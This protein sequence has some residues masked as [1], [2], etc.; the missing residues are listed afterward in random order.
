[1]AGFR[2]AA[3]AKNFEKGVYMMESKVYVP[4]SDDIHLVSSKNGSIMY[5]FFNV[6]SDN[7][8]VLDIGIYKQGSKWYAFIQGDNGKIWD[9]ERIS[10]LDGD[11]FYMEVNF[12]SDEII[13]RVDGDEVLNYDPSNHWMTRELVSS[14]DIAHAGFEITLV[15]ADN[16]W[17]NFNSKASHEGDSL[18]A[19]FKNAKMKEC[20]IYNQ[21]GE[22]VSIKS[23]F[24][25][26]DGSKFDDEADEC[27]SV[28]EYTNGFRTS[29][30]LNKTKTRF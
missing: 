13:L 11:R 19:F 12:R 29:I 20:T 5:M 23:P 21:E 26:G 10:N 18:R 27:V 14:T 24:I 25:D 30:D 3:Q 22:R 16:D 2:A 6:N 8:A 9:A 4:D 15:P 28:Y 17:D 7:G 1:M